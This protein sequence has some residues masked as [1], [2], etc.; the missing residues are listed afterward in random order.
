MGRVRDSPTR[1]FDGVLAAC[2]QGSTTTP[3]IGGTATVCPVRLGTASCMLLA[4]RV[5]RGL[6]G[7]CWSHLIVLPVGAILC[8]SAAKRDNVVMPMVRGNRQLIALAGQSVD[9]AKSRTLAAV[10]LLF[11]AGFVAWVVALGG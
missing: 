3:C 11:C 1:G 9:S 7:V 2:V 4:V 5:V 6:I 10:L 8:E